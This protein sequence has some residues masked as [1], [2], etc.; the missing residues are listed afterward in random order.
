MATDPV[1]AAAAAAED[2]RN[3]VSATFDDIQYRLDPRRI[4]GDAV[5]RV[6]TGSRALAAHAGDVAK[7]HPIALGAAVAALGLALFAR[8]RLANATV[9][10]GDVATDYTDYDDD[11]SPP[12]A[13]AAAPQTLVGETGDASARNPG[14]SML[15]GLV[16]G[17]ALG[18]LLPVTA[19]ERRTLGE[20]GQRLGA[21]ARA[22]AQSVT[23]AMRTE[24]KA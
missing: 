11:Y 5:E 7:T 6:Q 17:A 3:R 24:A 19:T 13:S 15:F 1:E 14:V 22:A 23:D 2:A 18:A 12:A 8:N 20:T 21:A 4:V 10:L 9:D 16:A